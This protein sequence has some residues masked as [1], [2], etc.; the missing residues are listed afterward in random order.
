[1]EQEIHDGPTVDKESLK[2]QVRLHWADKVEVE[3][4][5][6]GDEEE[7]SAVELAHPVEEARS[8][9]SIDKA[10]LQTVP[11]DGWDT[12]P[13]IVA[14]QGTMIL[15]H[16]GA[17]LVAHT[18]TVLA[19]DEPA[20]I[21]SGGV[22]SA[23]ASACALLVLS[24]FLFDFK[25]SMGASLV[26]FGGLFIW[27]ALA[28]VS[29]KILPSLAAVLLIMFGIAGLDLTEQWNLAVYLGMSSVI[30]YVALLTVEEEQSYIT[31]WTVN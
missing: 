6:A 30:I 7:T 23:W 13:V 28:A 12:Y 11:R 9:D 8:A 3:A 20:T 4:G 18:D 25:T 22:S 14:D 24:V 26:T 29:Q 21:K 2:R 19:Q 16:G 10:E 1:M 15:P 5:A 27:E 31:E 17:V